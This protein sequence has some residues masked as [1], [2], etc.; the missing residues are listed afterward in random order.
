MD[1]PS[2]TRRLV[3]IGLVGLVWVGAS[4]GRR[5]STAATAI[6]EVLSHDYTSALQA[7]TSPPAPCFGDC[8]GDG[9]VTVEELVR[10]VNIALGTSPLDACPTSG[11]PCWNGDACVQ[12]VINCIIEAVNNAML[13]C[14]TLGHACGGGAGLVCHAGEVCDVHDPTC[15]DVHVSGTCVTRPAGCIALFAPVCACDGGTYSNDCERLAAGAP[16]WQHDGSC[17]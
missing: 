10:L 2:G 11:C 3:I 17:P 12:V 16:A 13:G 1:K 6:A 9:A 5:A 7:A 14:P 4:L 15:A 8:G